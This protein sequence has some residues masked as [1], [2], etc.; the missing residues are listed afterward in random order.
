V[1][2]LPLYKRIQ[3]LGKAVYAGVGAQDLE[4]IVRELDPR[5]L[6]IQTGARS[7]QEGEELLRKAAQWTAKYWGSNTSDR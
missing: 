6:L 3:A 5:K 1:H 4:T 7:K 2:W